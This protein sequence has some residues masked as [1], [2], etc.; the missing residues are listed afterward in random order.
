VYNH[1]LDKRIKAYEENK[2]TI[3]FNA[4]C[5]LLT[6]LKREF[7]WLKESDSTALQ[8]ALKNLDNAYQNF[9]RR[10]KKGERPG[11]PKFK[12]KKNNHKSYRAKVVGTTILQ[13]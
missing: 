7:E 3:G 4:C 10:V 5:N 8:S 6:E 2:E 9:F 1:F 13:S 12:S 11:F